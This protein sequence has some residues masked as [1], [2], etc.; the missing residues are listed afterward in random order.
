MGRDAGSAK[1]GLPPFAYRTFTQ[2]GFSTAWVETLWMIVRLPGTIRTVRPDILFCA[3]N[4]YAVV[5]LA[6]RLIMGRRCPV[7]VAKVSN[8][9]GR[10]DLRPVGRWFYRRWLRLQGRWIHA[11]VGMAPPMRAEIAEAMGVAARAVAIID[12][13]ALCSA[14]MDR[15]ATEPRLI[16]KTPGRRF[17]AAGRLVAQKNFSLLLHAFARGAAPADRLTIVGEGPHRAVLER[18]ARTL[19]IADR[20]SLPGFRAW[21]GTSFAR[22]DAF[23]LSSDYEGVPAVVVEALASGL[24]VIATDCSVS[25]NFLLDHGRFGSLVPVGDVSAFAK[26]IGRI[27]DQPF[28]AVAARTHV[29]RF[30]VERA[31]DTYLVAFHRAATRTVDS[32]DKSLSEVR[33]LPSGDV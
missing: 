33:L 18:L 29:A 27:V 6:M 30:T 1:G 14:E 16:A 15:L 26:A 24:P 21:V 5:M 32:A 4:T 17:V 22:A 25:M 10:A 12:D 8:D 2:P 13:P 9:L 11:F 3:G 23:L 19:G 7:I 28:C 20:V 31:A